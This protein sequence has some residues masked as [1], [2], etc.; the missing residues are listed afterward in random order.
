MKKAILS[1]ALLAALP[2]MAQQKASIRAAMPGESSLERSIEGFKKGYGSIKGREVD[3]VYYLANDHKGFTMQH[4]AHQLCDSIQQSDFTKYK[5]IFPL[6]GAA[7][8]GMY[9]AMGDSFTQII[10][11]DKDYSSISDFIPFSINVGID[12]LLLDCLAQWNATHQLPKQRKEGLDSEFVEFVFNDT[13]NSK[14]TFYDW[15][16]ENQ[17]FSEEDIDKVLTAEFWKQRYALFIDQAIKEEK[18]Y[19]KH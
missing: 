15:E 1:A 19:E 16:D 5:T 9:N 3:T 8:L 11:M 17:Q 6:A 2:M 7:N 4:R 18:A 14:G 13:W 10:G 12:A